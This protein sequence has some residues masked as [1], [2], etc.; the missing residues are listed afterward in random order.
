M[1][2]NKDYII[3]S[4]GI[5]IGTTTTQ[6]IVSNLTVQNISSGTLVPKIEITKKEVVHKSDIYFTPIKENFLVDDEKIQDI[7]KREYLKAGISAKEIDTGAVIITGETAKKENAKKISL[8][9]ASLAG[10][11]VVATAGGNLESIIAGKGSGAAEYSK[12]N[13]VTTANVD[14]GGGTSN[15]AVFQDG[16]VIDCCCLNVGGRI[17]EI[18]KDTNKVKYITEPMKRILKNLNLNLSVGDLVNIDILHKIAD[19]M[20]DILLDCLFGKKIS[21]L[22]EEL[23]MSNSLSQDYKINCVMVSGG[24]ANYV[25]NSTLE[26][27]MDLKSILRYGDIGPLL[28]QKITK[29]LCEKNIKLQK[30]FETIRATV[31]GAGV[32]IISI[33]GSTIHVNNNIL[34]LKNIPV[35]KPFNQGIPKDVDKISFIIEENIKKFYNKDCMENLS[36]AIPNEGYLSFSDISKLAKGIIQ[37]L[38]EL[39]ELG[40]P[41][42]VIM[43]Q[44]YGKVLGQTFRLLLPNTNIICIDQLQVSEGDYVDIGKFIPTGEVVP[45]VIKTLVFATKQIPF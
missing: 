31:I 17:I 3:K 26:D 35:I 20:V 25:Y 21:N 42:I 12:K 19:K 7:I 10:D 29:K 32:Q 1:L 13:Y 8:K 36:I 16:K 18:E 43:E 4:V 33:S 24:V 38:N 22:T 5:D 2:K 34:P 23:L 27:N 41:I 14:I 39:I 44:D 28:G 15:I 37:G 30:P 11:F 45:V 40:K 9:I 6:L